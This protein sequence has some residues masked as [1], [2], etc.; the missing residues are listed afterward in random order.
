[1]LFV[2]FF[3]YYNAEFNDLLCKVAEIAKL[4]RFC[5]RYNNNRM[6]AKNPSHCNSIWRQSTRRLATLLAQ[7]SHYQRAF[8]SSLMRCIIQI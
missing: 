8:A 2:F 1:M 3:A 6:W 7:K 4:P 5:W